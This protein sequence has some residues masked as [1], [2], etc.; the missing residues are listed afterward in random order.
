MAINDLRQP[1]RYRRR[2]PSIS[3]SAHGPRTSSSGSSSSAAGISLRAPRRHGPRPTHWP[4]AAAR[5]G[6]MRRRT[7]R[8]ST[9]RLSR[10]RIFRVVT[11]IWC[12]AVVDIRPG[13]R[14]P[15]SAACR[16]PR[17]PHGAPDRRA[18]GAASASV[19]VCQHPCQLEPWPAGARPRPATGCSA[20]SAGPHPR[21]P[22]ASVRPSTSSSSHSRHCCSR[23]RCRRPAAHAVTWSSANSA[24]AAPSAPYR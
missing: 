10:L 14:D 21:V 8:T 13:Q 2:A 18:G 11:R 20:C 1:E 17:P 24:S 22:G 19:E 7:T 6:S 23:A 16:S 4:A 5:R 12:T 9:G 3:R 15:T